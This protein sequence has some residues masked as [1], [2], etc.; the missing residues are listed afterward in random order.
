MS[1]IVVNDDEFVKELEKKPPLLLAEFSQ[2]GLLP[3]LSPPGEEKEKGK[4]KPGYPNPSTRQGV[5]IDELAKPEEF[6]GRVVILRVPMASCSETVKKY[7]VSAA[8][9]VVIFKDGEEVLR[10]VDLHL[11]FW[12]RKKL[13]EL[14]TPAP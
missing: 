4:E 10:E 8:P 13:N 5:V 3:E 2:P 6:G 12:Y 11:I 1:V 7:N 9:T 14:L